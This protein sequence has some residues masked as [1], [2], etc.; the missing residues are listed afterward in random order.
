VTSCFGLRFSDTVSNLRTQMSRTPSTSRSRQAGNR[1]V[2]H[3]R[4]HVRA[5]VL[6][7]DFI[8]RRMDA[9]KRSDDLDGKP[10]DGK[11]G[12]NPNAAYSYGERRAS[13]QCHLLWPQTSERQGA[14]RRFLREN[15]TC[16]HRWLA[17]FRS[18]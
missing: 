11:S 12:V 9:L 10:I 17:P 14:S 2:S 16:I 4:D 1:S 6:P 7:D 18:K 13:A 5:N 3:R 8:G 15:V